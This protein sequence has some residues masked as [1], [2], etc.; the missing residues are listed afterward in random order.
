M[1]GMSGEI[2]GKSKIDVY[3]EYQEII[4]QWGGTFQTINPDP[5]YKKFCKR[6]MVWDLDTGEWVLNYHLHT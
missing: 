1:G 3:I 6:Q 5:K 4:E 2:K